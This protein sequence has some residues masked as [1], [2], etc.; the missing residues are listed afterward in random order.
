MS[1]LRLLT[2]FPKMCSPSE[3][4]HSDKSARCRSACWRICFV[5]GKIDK[6][7]I[8]IK[9]GRT[10][11]IRIHL[12]NNHTGEF[13][14]LNAGKKTVVGGGNSM[15]A[16]HFKPRGKEMSLEDIKVTICHGSSI[17]G[18]RQ[19]SAIQ[20]VCQC[21]LSENVSAPKQRCVKNY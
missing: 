15:I 1:L 18:H 3:G 14:I 6:G 5:V 11:V 17:M 13:K 21:I 10:G 12:L 20:D 7:T 8:S 16:N 9:G 2:N 19:G 4:T